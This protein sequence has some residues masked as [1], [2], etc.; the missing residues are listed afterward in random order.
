MHARLLP[1]EQAGSRKLLPD[2][3]CPVRSMHETVK[4]RHGSASNLDQGQAST[5]NSALYH[6]L[7]L[8][9]HPRMSIAQE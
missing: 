8:V 5:Y 7:Y 2:L 9:H 6:V 3:N 1:R 4:M